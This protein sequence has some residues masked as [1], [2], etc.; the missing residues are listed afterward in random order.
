VEAKTGAGVALPVYAK[1]VGLGY[2][3]RHVRLPAARLAAAV[4][5]MVG[6]RHGLLFR[7]WLPEETRVTPQRLRA[8][9]AHVAG[10]IARYVVARSRALPL[11]EDFTL[12]LQRLEPVWEYIAHMLGDAFGGA[13]HLVRL[14]AFVAARRLVAVARPSVTDGRTS[15]WDWY[16]EPGGALRKIHVQQRGSSNTGFRSCDPIFDLADAAAAAEAAG[17]E[18]FGDR[19]KRDYE[20]LTGGRVADERWLL[21]RLLHHLGAYRTSLRTAALG[22]AH[23]GPA[24]AA[25]LRIERTMADVHRRYFEERYFADLVPA[26]EG[27]FCAIDIDGVLE[28]RWLAFP[29][30]APAGAAALRALAL[31]HYRAL[32]VTGRSLDDVR[33]RCRAFRLPGGVAEYGAVVYDHV[34]GCERHLLGPEERAALAALREALHAVDGVCL[35]PLHRSSVRV[36]RLDAAGARRGLAEETI[37]AVIARAGVEGRVRAVRGGLQTDFVPA[38]VDKG[39]GLVALLE[40]LA[41]GGRPGRVALAVGDSASDLPMFALA[42]RAVAPANAAGELRR[43]V[44]LT[45]RPYGAGLLDAVNEQV[46]HGRRCGRCGPRPARGPSAAL[47]QA[48][49]GALDGGR[50]GKLRHAA[51]LLLALASGM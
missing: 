28:T 33:A 51:A 44:E 38:G 12:R 35:D 30:I 49:L 5:P 40:Q 39:R 16:G 1:G 26:E 20:A 10:A 3:G 46:G 34:H 31:H 47:L 4:P 11:D 41:P 48:A 21:Y 36:H 14:L 32:L 18:S 43:R 8:E 17:D 9:G 7:L 22:P 19:L 24:L 37:A 6:V 15:P 29:A 42:A 27:P 25:A 13:R 45:R 50:L 23:A 2:F